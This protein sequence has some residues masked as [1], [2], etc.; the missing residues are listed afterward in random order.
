[1]FAFVFDD[2]IIVYIS[3]Q[4]KNKKFYILYELE[5]A[6][7]HKG[8]LLYTPDGDFDKEFADIMCESIYQ[9]IERKVR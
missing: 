7:Y 8:G 2:S 4:A 5:P 1:L 6:P 3:F 9:F